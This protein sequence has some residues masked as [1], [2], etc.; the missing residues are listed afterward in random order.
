MRTVFD[1]R[2]VRPVPVGRGSFMSPMQLEVPDDL[3]GDAR[4]EFLAAALAELGMLE[5]G[6]FQ[7]G[8]VGMVDN[9]A[10]R[11]LNELTGG[12]YS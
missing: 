1:N 5:P 2:T 4:A 10:T 8:N 6:V 9:E 7:G 11:A 3:V 12:F